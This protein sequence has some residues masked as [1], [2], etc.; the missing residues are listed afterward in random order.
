VQRPTETKIGGYG[1]LTDGRLAEVEVARGR[2][3]VVCN[4]WKP[5]LHTQHKLVCSVSATRRATGQAS[6]PADPA[7]QGSLVHLWEL[8]QHGGRGSDGREGAGGNDREERHARVVG[9]C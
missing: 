3:P 1:A 5:R 4:V 9:H 2:I 6:P 8:M 7:S